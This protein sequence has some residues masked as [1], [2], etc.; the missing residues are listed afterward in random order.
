MRQFQE[1]REGGRHLARGICRLDDASTTDSRASG[2][3]GPPAMQ[4]A[5]M[6]RRTRVAVAPMASRAALAG[7]VVESLM[8]MLRPQAPTAACSCFIT[9]STLPQLHH[10]SSSPTRLTATTAAQRIPPAPSPRL[11]QSL[12]PPSRYL[13]RPLPDPSRRARILQGS[14][15]AKAVPPSAKNLRGAGYRFHPVTPVMNLAAPRG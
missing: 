12:L 1:A 3:G 13:P 11:H 15:C 2:E 8:S 4:S 7:G 10:A 6:P 9:P 14:V 5:E